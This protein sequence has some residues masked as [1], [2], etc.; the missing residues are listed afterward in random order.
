MIY[1]YIPF[2]VSFYADIRIPAGNGRL[3]LC[4]INQS[5]LGKTPR[6]DGSMNLGNKYLDVHS[7]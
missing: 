2:L 6:H 5:F 3:D 1:Q 4:S 7:T